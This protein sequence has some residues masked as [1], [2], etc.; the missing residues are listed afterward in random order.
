[1]NDEIKQAGEIKQVDALTDEE[2]R[3][4]FGWGENIF[5]VTPYA[6]TWRSKDLHFVFYS[7]QKPVSHVGILKHDVSVG[8]QSITVGGVGGVV[9]V[10]EAQKKGT[11]RRVVEHAMSFLDREWA[12]D[13]G[14]L[15]CFPK[16]EDYYA[17]LGWETIE[18]PVT[19]DQP[20][21]KIISPLLVMVLPLRRTLWPTG[22][23]D[24]QSLPW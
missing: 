13:A 21:G 3:L 15:F 20:A 4:L 19:I 1:M 9:S 10:P 5:G 6:M 8:G 24:L 12:V 2:T 16:M 18:G 7:D 23:V 22:P 11:A 14:L 17:R